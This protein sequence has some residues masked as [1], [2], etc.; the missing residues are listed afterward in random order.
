MNTKEISKGIVWAVIQLLGISI[1][2]WLLF[3]LQAL[4]IYMVIAGVISLIGRPINRFFIKRLRFKN[5]LA[6]SLTLFILLSILVSVFSLFVPLLIQ[7]GENLSLLDVESLKI[8]TETLI[9]EISLYFKVDNSF[10]N[11][12]LLLII[13]FKM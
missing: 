5:A 10:G 8:T 1:V 13:F 11:A 12:S 6:T 3:Q 7:Q 9:Q 4:I 2:L